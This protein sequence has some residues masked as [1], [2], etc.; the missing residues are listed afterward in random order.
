MTQAPDT[1]SSEPLRLL[2]V[3]DSE[4][5]FE[6]LQAHLRRQGLHARCHR[7]ETEAA[8][9]DALAAGGWDAI[10]SDHHLPTFSG[11]EAIRVA[12]ACAPDLAVIIVSGTI[13]EDRAVAAMRGG[14]DDYLLKDNPARL[15]VALENAMDAARARA[16]RRRAERALLESR[17]QLRALS[18][19]LQQTI[20]G[21]RQTIARELHDEIGSGLTA[22]NY[23][24]AWLARR[25]DPATAERARRAQAHLTGLLDSVQAIMRRLRPPILDSGLLPALEWQIGQFRQR[26]GLPVSFDVNQADLEVD[27]ATALTLYR[28]LQEALTNIAKHARA[29]RV[30]ASLIASG[31]EL[32][33][34]ISDDGIGIPPLRERREQAFGLRGLAER[35]QQLGG[36]LEASRGPDG[37]TSVLVS[38]PLRTPVKEL[39]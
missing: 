22:L 28:A 14:A 12:R 33:L 39:P 30:H 1:G 7:V 34:E 38:L 23:D 11:E 16:R 31:D 25:D 19:H 9:R 26:T 20:E 21:E 2:V 32:S 10:V 15:R 29:S 24:L 17:Q 4:G 18:A 3:E 5:D 27:D 37:G 6:L 13:G 35:V 36:L 8:M